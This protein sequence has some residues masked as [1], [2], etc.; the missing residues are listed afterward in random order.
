M[1]FYRGVGSRSCLDGNFHEFSL[2]MV[3]IAISPT[4]VGRS[5]K[6]RRGGG[7]GPPSVPGRT[8]R[9]SACPGQTSGKKALSTP[10]LTLG[11]SAPQ[12][13]PQKGPN[14]LFTAPGGSV[15]QGVQ[16][17]PHRAT[18]GRKC[19]QGRWFS[20]PRFGRV[21][22]PE[23]QAALP[24]KWPA[25]M[26]LTSFSWTGDQLSGTQTGSQEHPTFSASR[27][28]PSSQTRHR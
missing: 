21:F 13:R 28:S 18:Q 4:L 5:G 17:A 3:D 25:S 27:S 11:L 24:Q 19:R 26:V 14:G 9:R 7:G 22:R 12:N 2:A 23:N 16:Q 8:A 10:A 1:S 6:Y 20:T 15:L